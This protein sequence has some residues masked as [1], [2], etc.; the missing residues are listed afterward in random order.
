MKTGSELVRFA[1]CKLE[2]NRY[3]F[4]K[5]IF[6]KFLTDIWPVAVFLN[7]LTDIFADI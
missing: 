6:S 5:P 7:L 2:T 1:A 4:M 3:F